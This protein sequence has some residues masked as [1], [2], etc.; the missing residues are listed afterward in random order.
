MK[1]ENRKIPVTLILFVVCAIVV[2]LFSNIREIMDYPKIKAAGKK[3]LMPVDIKQKTRKRYYRGR[4]TSSVTNYVKF[5]LEI[6]GKNL[7][8]WMPAS[9]AYGENSPSVGLS[10]IR[11]KKKIE[12]YIFYTDDNIYYS[13]KEATVSGYIKESIINRIMVLGMIIVMSGIV[14]LIYYVI[15]FF[16]TKRK[17]K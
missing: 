3:N 16:A 5:T 6:N 2:G 17:N 13:E 12:R 1:N 7:A 15:A 14:F 8:F 9:D 11:E 10:A 4:T